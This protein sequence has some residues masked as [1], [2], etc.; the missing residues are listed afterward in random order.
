M[1]PVYLVLESRHRWLIIV[2]IASGAAVV[3]AI[4]MIVYNWPHLL[5]RIWFYVGLAVS[6]YAVWRAFS[7]W[8]AGL[9]ETRAPAPEAH[10][11]GLSD[12]G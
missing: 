7:D 12:E 4:L 9:G 8:R 1:N 2:A 3:G 6:L 5:A 10:A 11:A